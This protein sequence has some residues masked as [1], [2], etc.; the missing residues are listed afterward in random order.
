M[1]KNLHDED[2]DY[3]TYLM[4]QYWNKPDFS[5]WHKPSWQLSTKE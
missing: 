1:L 3:I 4:Q 2:I 5:F